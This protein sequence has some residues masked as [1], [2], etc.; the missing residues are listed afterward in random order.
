[1]ELTTAS[2]KISSSIF[3][4]RKTEDIK[5]SERA[6]LDFEY[7]AKVKKKL[8]EVESNIAKTLEPDG[9]PDCNPN[10]PKWPDC[11]HGNTDKILQVLTET[12]PNF[13]PENA[14]SSEKFEMIMEYLEEISKNPS[15]IVPLL[16]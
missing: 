2:I 8:S 12:I 3:S 9:P 6:K 7:V 11:Q 15:M 5:P 10:N 1:M 13:I 4:G 14:S 16:S